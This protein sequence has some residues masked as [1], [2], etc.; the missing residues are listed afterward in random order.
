MGTHRGYSK[1]ALQQQIKSV[2]YNFYKTYFKITKPTGYVT[3]QQVCTFR[4]HFMCF[5][6]I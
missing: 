3:H 1:A 6:F 4:P 5:V 2:V